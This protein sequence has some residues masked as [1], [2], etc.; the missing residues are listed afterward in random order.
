MYP[1]LIT[2]SDFNVFLPPIGG[3]SIYIFGPPSYISDP[4]KKLTV[5]VVSHLFKPSMT[6]VTVQTCL[7]RISVR[8]VH[9]SFTALPSAYDKHNKE[10]L[11]LLCISERK[12]ERLA[13]SPNT[14]STMRV[15]V[16]KAVTPRQT[17]FSAPKTW[18]VSK[19][20]GSKQQCLTS[21]IG[22]VCK[23]LTV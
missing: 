9:T 22:W 2:R 12:V 17:T 15:N 7:G 18:P 11:D 20:C 5:R 6:S 16:L 13:K 14:S 8:A 3:L 21:S 23:R 1:E 4:T 19:T 10:V